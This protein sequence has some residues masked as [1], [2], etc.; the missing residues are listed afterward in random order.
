M[1]NDKFKQLV[2]LLT[3]KDAASLEVQKW[4]QCNVDI[5]KEYSKI[6]ANDESTV[7]GIDEIEDHVID[8]RII[9]ISPELLQGVDIISDSKPFEESFIAA[10]PTISDTQMKEIQRYVWK[11]GEGLN[12]RSG[13]CGWHGGVDGTICHMTNRITMSYIFENSR[14]IG[15]DFGCGTGY[16]ALIISFVTQYYMIG[17]E[18]CNK[19][20][21]FLYHTLTGIIFYV[22]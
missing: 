9:N 4:M 10:N 14:G 13:S 3:E 8:F 7:D 2:S 5:F 19:C 15:I 16:S 1:D 6:V 21:I 22:V 20:R 18:V 12:M 11:C 17:V